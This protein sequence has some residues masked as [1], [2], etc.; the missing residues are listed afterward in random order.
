MAHIHRGAAGEDGL[1]DWNTNDTESTTF[2]NFD[3]WRQLSVALPGHYPSDNYN[4]PRNCNWRHRGGNGLVDY[5]LS[6]TGLVIELREN[7]VYIDELVE[8]A[9]R[10]I[11][12]SELTCGASARKEIPR[13]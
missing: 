11:M 3:G 4:W 9:S 2:V 13:R 8:A 6:L 12:L 10:S 7:L 5:P 1:A